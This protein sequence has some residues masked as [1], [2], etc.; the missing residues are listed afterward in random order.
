MHPE[1]PSQAAIQAG[2]AVGVLESVFGPNPAIPVTATDLNDPNLKREYKSIVEMA[3]E[4]KNVRIWGGVHFR[5]TL[6][7][8]EDMG[9]KIAV[10]LSENSL[11]PTR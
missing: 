8:G 11:K 10:Y 3:D 9:R 4:Q 7:V 1:Y 5:N 6:E 2:V